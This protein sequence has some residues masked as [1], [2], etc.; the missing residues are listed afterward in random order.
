MFSA[1]ILPSCGRMPYLLTM[2]P[3]ENNPDPSEAL[4]IKAFLQS[5]CASLGTNLS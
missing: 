3:D 5:L 4:A 2:L 1:A